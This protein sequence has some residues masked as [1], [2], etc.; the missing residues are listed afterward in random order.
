MNG[1]GTDG[2]HVHEARQQSLL[3][4]WA[5]HRLEVIHAN[6]DVFPPGFRTWFIQNKHIA[7]EVW[8]L[9]DQARA[10]GYRNWSMRAALHVLRWE[11]ATTGEGGARYKIN[12]NNSALL[13]RLY[14]LD[15]L[16]PNGFFRTRGVQS[17]DRV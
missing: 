7:R 15:P 17:P 12:N 9:A 3:V 10:K 4:G 13:A 5:F 16:T 2:I 8:R 6:P 11:T 1:H 14:N